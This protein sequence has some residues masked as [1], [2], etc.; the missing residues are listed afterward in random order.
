M[1]RSVPP[2]GHISAA[3]KDH[4]TTVDGPDVFD[5]STA[6]EQR[7]AD[8]AG[9]QPAID[10]ALE[11]YCP[12]VETDTIGGVPVLT[13]TPQS[14]RADTHPL[15]YMFGGGFCVGSPD[16]ELPVTAALADALG[17]R[18][19]APYYRL[20]PEHPYPAALEDVRTV[21]RALLDDGPVPLVAGESAGGNLS[22]ALTVSVIADN[23][24]PPRALA[25]L[26]PACDLAGNGDSVELL[27]GVAPCYDYADRIGAIAQCYAGDHA[28]DDPLVSPLFADF[29]ARFP[30]TLITTGTRDFF[31]SDC[32][33]LSQRL[34]AAGAD[35]RLHVWDGMWHV[36]EWYA[37]TPEAEQSLA[38]IG[39]FLAEFA[40]S[41]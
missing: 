40:Q 23:V 27:R 15:L 3:A 35:A 33:R 29:D 5:P 37:N 6:P 7:A 10:A 11:R 39:A 8:R 34:R 26:S 36:F 28:V 19:I 32:A 31:L 24:T 4:L 22:L 13:V 2:P 25:L 17:C 14:F 18:V 1:T 30:P 9:R 41:G 12:A 38:E 20:I 21:Y 16:E